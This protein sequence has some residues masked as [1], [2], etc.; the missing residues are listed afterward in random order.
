[1]CFLIVLQSCVE[2]VSKSGIPAAIALGLLKKIILAI[3]SCKNSDILVINS[4]LYKQ[5]Q[6]ASWTLHPV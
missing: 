1:M 3:S 5:M 6:Q 4:G 2:S